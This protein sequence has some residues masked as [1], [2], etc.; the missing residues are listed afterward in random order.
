MLK[1]VVKIG[2]EV[3]FVLECNERG[4]KRERPTE[5]FRWKLTFGLSPKK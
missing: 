1:V 4:R 2:R 5:Y 3:G